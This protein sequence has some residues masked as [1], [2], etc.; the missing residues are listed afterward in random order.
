MNDIQ[1]QINEN[2]RMLAKL[3]DRW[4]REKKKEERIKSL[5]THTTIATIQVV[6]D[7]K[8]FS[9]HRTPSP[10]GPINGDANTSTIGQEGSLNLE[11]TKRMSL[12]DI[13]I[14]LINDSNLDFDNCNLSEVIA[15]L[16]RMAK[17]P[18][19]STLNIALTGHI[20]NALI[21]AREKKLK[22]ESS[23]PRNLE[24]GWHPMVKINLNNISCFAL[25]DVGA[26]ASVMPKRMYDMLD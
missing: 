22:L 5:P 16:Q 19:T 3:K 20:T 10:N 2:I 8:T 13:T 15:F 11:T 1:V 26:S 18:H 9:T 4:A 6:E 14:T 17:D 12:D 21:K 24:D 7:L 25:C 23:I